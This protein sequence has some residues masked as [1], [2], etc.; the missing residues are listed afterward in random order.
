MKKSD[1]F[2]WIIKR[3][4]SRIV[5]GGGQ[6]EELDHSVSPTVSS[7]SVEFYRLTNKQ[8]TEIRK[9]EQEE[10]LKRYLRYQCQEL[11]K[12]CIG[13]E[14]YENC[15]YEVCQDTVQE[16]FAEEV[17][18]GLCENEV[19]DTSCKGIA[20]EAYEKEV[21]HKEVRTEIVE[22]EPIFSEESFQTTENSSGIEQVYEERRG[23][24]SS[25]K[26]IKEILDQNEEVDIQEQARQ[27]DNSI[28]LTKLPERSNYFRDS[29]NFTKDILTKNTGIGN[30][31][32][33]KI[34]QNQPRRRFLD[35][36]NRL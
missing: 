8:K 31:R 19:A 28:D 20:E 27:A 16:A 35:I 33:P 32:P 15:V 7:G 30:S 14:V 11:M 24:E 25:R 21:K 29:D 4:E 17:T 26:R 22:R 9:R 2:P 10:G 23:G 13:T 1:S 6:D 5:Y 3:L 36:V 34:L 12:E 18:S